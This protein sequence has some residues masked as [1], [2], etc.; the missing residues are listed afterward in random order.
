MRAKINSIPRIGNPN[1]DTFSTLF[2]GEP[3]HLRLYEFL[4]LVKGGSLRLWF[5]FYPGELGRRR[6]LGI[7]SDLRQVHEIS[8]S[9]RETHRHCERRLIFL[10][11]VGNH[12]RTFRYCVRRTKVCREYQNEARRPIWNMLDWPS[13][14]DFD[15]YARSA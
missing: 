6:L 14:L 8:E 9:I 1:R 3:I 10:V 11:K 5:E 12:Q 15:R 13:E 4:D 2:E 7:K